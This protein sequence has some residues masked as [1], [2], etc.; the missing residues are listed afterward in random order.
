M[1]RKIYICALQVDAGR[2]PRWI[3]PRTIGLRK[4]KS[5]ENPSPIS[6]FIQLLSGA[7]HDASNVGRGCLILAR[8]R[9]PFYRTALMP[10]HDATTPADT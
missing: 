3:T 8:G 10:V 6:Y 9:P 7:G 4:N 2:R 1:L 5:R